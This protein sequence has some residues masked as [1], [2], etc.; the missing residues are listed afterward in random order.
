MKDAM[1]ERIGKIKINKRKSKK[2]EWKEK[3]EEKTSF[4]LQQE[5]TPMTR[6]HGWL[7]INKSEISSDWTEKD[8]HLVFFLQK[9][10]KY[11]TLSA[12]DCR[13]INKMSLYFTLMFLWKNIKPGSQIMKSHYISVILYIVS[14][15]R[16]WYLFGDN[17]IWVY[18]FIYEC[19]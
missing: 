10:S 5:R 14:I 15:D 19:W 1:K 13:K 7:I 3:K 18:L 12:K 17:V 8:Q 2:K 6:A 9:F 16:C 11:W 4:K